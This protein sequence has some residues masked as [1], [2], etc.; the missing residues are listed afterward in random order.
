MDRWTHLIPAGLLL[1]VPG[2]IDDMDG[3][4]QHAPHWLQFIVFSL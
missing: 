1:P 3:A 2:I 4:M